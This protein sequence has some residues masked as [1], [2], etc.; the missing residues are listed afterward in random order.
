[1]FLDSIEADIIIFRFHYTSFQVPPEVTPFC[2]MFSV[3]SFDVKKIKG[4]SVD[5]Q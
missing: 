5:V 2:S 3:I 4:K 1:M